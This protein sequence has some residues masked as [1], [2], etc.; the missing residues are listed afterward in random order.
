MDSNK[1]HSFNE[2]IGVVQIATQ[3]GITFYHDEIWHPKSSWIKYLAL[4][5]VSYVDS[6]PSKWVMID[7]D[8]VINVISSVALDRLN[9]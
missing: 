2:F 8:L 5:I 4:Y 3:L 1:P 6:H 7:N 9:S